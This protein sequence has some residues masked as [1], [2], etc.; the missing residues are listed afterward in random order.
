MYREEH[1][2]LAS[3]EP[4]IFNYLLFY[5]SFISVCTVHD[6]IALPAASTEQSIGDGSRESNHI[7]R[8]PET[9]K[10]QENT[11]TYIHA[12][13]CRSLPTRSQTLSNMLKK[14]AN[15]ATVSK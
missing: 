3:M 5:S 7:H 12:M 15:A 8:E 4:I 13:T 11:H 2:K 9:R 10:K 6:S 14:H 1:S